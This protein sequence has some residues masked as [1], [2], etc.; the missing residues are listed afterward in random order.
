MQEALYCN[1]MSPAYCKDMGIVTI[2]KIASA[3]DL[4]QT[5]PSGFFSA[6]KDIQRFVTGSE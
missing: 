1:V 4:I 2:P 5:S 6:S 3:P